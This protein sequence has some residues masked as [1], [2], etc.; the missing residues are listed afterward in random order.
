MPKRTAGATLAI[1]AMILLL[2]L[3]GSCAR[4]D[5]RLVSMRNMEP[6]PP[7]PER[8]AEL[9]RLIAGYEEIAADAI[10]AAIEQADALK[11]LGQ[12]YMRQELYGPALDAYEQAIRIEPSNHVLHY[13]AAVAAGHTGKAQAR[14]EVREEYLRRAERSYLLSIEHEPDYIDARYGLGVLYVFELGEPARA[15]EHLEAALDRN[16][17][18]VPSL[19]VLARAH[20]ALGNVDDAVDAYDRIIRVSPESEA[21]ERAERNRRLLLGGSS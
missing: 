6:D 3:L 20:V 21:R 10:Q 18:H 1:T 5:A 2:A 16:E 13:L 19:F 12:E 4:E 9:E 14:P 17:N 15:I 11:L 7:S 8:V